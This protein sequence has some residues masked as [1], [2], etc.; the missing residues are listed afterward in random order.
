MYTE[1][2]HAILKHLLNSRGSYYWFGEKIGDNGPTDTF[3]H[4]TCF[5]GTFSFTHSTPKLTLKKVEC[6]RWEQ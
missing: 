4:L 2:V 3:H 6:C 1:S 5:T